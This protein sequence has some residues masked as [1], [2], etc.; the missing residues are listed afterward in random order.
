MFCS[1]EFEFCFVSPAAADAFHMKQFRFRNRLDTCRRNKNNE[2]ESHSNMRLKDLT[3]HSFWG[4][5][6]SGLLLCTTSRIRFRF[7]VWHTSTD[8]ADRRLTY[9]L[10]LLL[11]SHQQTRVRSQWEVGIGHKSFSSVLTDFVLVSCRLAWR[12][13]GVGSLTIQEQ[14]NL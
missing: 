7:T 8:F 13:N 5:L 3:F 6:F 14:A 12:I 10:S 2:K 1:F 4:W 9:I 11:A